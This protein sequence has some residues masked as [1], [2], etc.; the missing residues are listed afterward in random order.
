MRK[1]EYIYYEWFFY[2][3]ENGERIELDGACR[4]NQLDKGDIESWKNH[5]CIVEEGVKCVGEIVLMKKYCDEDGVLFCDYDG[6][7]IRDDGTLPS[8]FYLP[9]D[10]D[11]QPVEFDDNGEELPKEITFDRLGYDRIPKYIHKHL[12]KIRSK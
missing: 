7:A 12:E 8:H 1:G 5:E 9:D 11:L 4:W 6:E 10:D 3:Y 2:H